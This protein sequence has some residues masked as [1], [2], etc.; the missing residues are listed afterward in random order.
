[1]RPAA[2]P[3][4]PTRLTRRGWSKGTARRACA[5]ACRRRVKAPSIARLTCR[6]PASSSSLSPRTRSTSSCTRRGS[7]VAR[8]ERPVLRLWTRPPPLHESPVNLEVVWPADAKAG[9]TATLRVMLRHSREDASRST[10]GSRCRPA[11]RSARRTKGA[12][13]VQGVL[14]LR[15]PFDSSGAIVEIPVR[16]GLPEGHGARGDSAHRPLVLGSGDR[17]GPCSGRSLTHVGRER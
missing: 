8:F 2:R 3:V 14:A 17:A 9:A 6:P 11:S 13:Q 1:M 16:F 10:R 15:E 4:S 5:C 7:L 12:A